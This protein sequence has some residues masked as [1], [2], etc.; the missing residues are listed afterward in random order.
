MA[1][2]RDGVVNTTA[3]SNVITGVG[4]VW[5]SSMVGGIFVFGSMRAAYTIIAVASNTSMTI[6]ANSPYTGTSWEYIISV[7][8]TSNL[9]LPLSNPGDRFFDSLFN[10]AMRKLDVAIGG[11]LDYIGTVEDKDLNAAPT[12]GLSDGDAYIVASGVSTGDAWFGY[13]NYIA[14]W[15]AATGGGWSF[16]APSTPITQ[17]GGYVWVR[18]ESEIY[19][20]DGE[21]WTLYNITGELNTGSS[22]TF[23]MG[24]LTTGGDLVITHNLNERHIGHVTIYD[25]SH[26]PISPDWT[27]D[28]PTQCTALISGETVASGETWYWTVSKF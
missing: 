15:D 27:A 25:H 9:S 28:S 7:D 3:G 8:F 19:F 24:D 1:Q 18:D 26:V 5:T 16:A 2:Y 21:S 17:G 23:G 6:S 11:G 10:D 13:E 14:I 12:T 20:W 22:G 4:T